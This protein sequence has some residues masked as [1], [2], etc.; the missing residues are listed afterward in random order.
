MEGLQSTQGG[1]EFLDDSLSVD[2]GH[3]QHVFPVLGVIYHI[4]PAGVA[5]P[6][7]SHISEKKSPPVIHWIVEI[8]IASTAVRFEGVPRLATNVPGLG[9]RGRAAARTRAELDVGAV[10]DD[11]RGGLGVGE[12]YDHGRRTIVG[13]GEVGL[14]P[15]GLWDVCCRRWS[16]LW[17]HSHGRHGAHAVARRAAF[18]HWRHSYFLDLMVVFWATETPPPPPRPRAA[19]RALPQPRMIRDWPWV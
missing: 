3:L 19:D 7:D 18:S 5:T 15:M 6:A 8:P 14:I 2:V 9:F 17:Y 16:A 1:L 12:I 10:E 11:V 13:P 4:V